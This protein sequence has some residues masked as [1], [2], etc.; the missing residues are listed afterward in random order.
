M[1]YRLKPLATIALAVILITTAYIYRGY[2][3][4]SR[5]SILPQ[6]P[7]EVIMSLENAYLVGVGK[8]GKVWSAKAKKV[9]ISFDRT[10]AMFDDINDAKIFD[11]GKLKLR[12]RA[13]R[14]VYNTKTKNVELSDGISLEGNEGQT[15]KGFG[16]FWNSKT[17]ELRSSGNVEFRN[18]WSVCKANSLLVNLKNKEMT[19]DNVIMTVEIETLEKD[20]ENEAHKGAR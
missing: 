5:S 12:A 19:L 3:P 10:T 4:Y 7:P 8:K 18:K 16:A 20:T 17:S 2:L 1:R 9:E 14:A 15:V 13:G 6:N 11:E